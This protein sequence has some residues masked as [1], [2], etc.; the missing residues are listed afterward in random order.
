M[1]AKLGIIAALPFEVASFAGMDIA[2]DSY[3]IISEDSFIYYAGVGA[4][5]ATQAAQFLIDSKV[6]ALVS[7][8]SAGALD[9]VLIPGDIV[10]P[11]N[12]I[13]YVDKKQYRV[14][15]RWH[16]ALKT[17][18]D[19]NTTYSAGSIVSTQDVQHSPQK[20]TNLY[21]AI[22]AAAVDMESAAIA[23]VASKEKKPFIVIRSISDTAAMQLPKSAIN[24]TDE[25]GRVSIIA[26]FAGLMKN[27]TELF[28][29]PRLIHSLAKTKKSLRGIV[30]LCGFDLCINEVL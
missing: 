19:I 12:V 3:E 16:A 26:L 15:E 30:R 27:P 8:G 4:K 24:G 28:H 1:S 20:K 29:Y 17:K 9:P 7:W 11:V 22:E 13:N 6:D 2:P 10:L 5:N 14:N 21:Q 23:A 18:L 25:Y